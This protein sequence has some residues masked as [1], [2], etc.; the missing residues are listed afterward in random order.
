MQRFIRLC[1]TARPTPAENLSDVQSPAFAHP[2]FTK[3]ISVDARRELQ[4]NIAEMAIIFLLGAVDGGLVEVIQ[5]WF[6][7]RPGPYNKI[8]N[9][10]M[11]MERV[12]THEMRKMLEGVL[13]SGVEV[14]GLVREVEGQTERSCLEEK[15]LGIDFA[16]D[17]REEIY[18]ALLPDMVEFDNT[19][20]DVA[21]LAM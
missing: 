7:R 14:D 20:V 4:E 15:Y 12:K 9:F 13:Q 21:D 11:L 16:L 8:N 2:E 1:V 5:R 10:E 6:D 18:K 3:R 19:E 17:N